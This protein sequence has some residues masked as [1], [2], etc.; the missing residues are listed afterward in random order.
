MKTTAVS[1]KWLAV[2]W[3]IRSAPDWLQ[4]VRRSLRDSIRPSTFEVVVN[5]VPLDQHIS[6]E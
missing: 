2:E 1:V 5:Q 4:Y 3:A 6:T